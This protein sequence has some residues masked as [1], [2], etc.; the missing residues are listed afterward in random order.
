MRTPVLSSNM[1]RPNEIDSGSI[2]LKTD[3]S[4]DTDLPTQQLRASASSRVAVGS[5]M[6]RV[7]TDGPVHRVD[8]SA[9]GLPTVNLLSGLELVT[10][11]P[12]SEARL[13][14]AVGSSRFGFELLT[15]LG[16]GAFGRVYLARQSALADR[17][18]VLKVGTH[19]SDETQ[20]L[21]QLQHPNVA[22]VYSFHRDGR[23]QALCMPYLGPVTLA[24]VM[25]R[26]RTS[27]MSTLNGKALTTAIVE[28]RRVK[29][30]T[31]TAIGTT[32]LHHTGPTAPQSGPS[33]ASV[34]PQLATSPGRIKLDGLR[35]YNYVDAVLWVCQQLADGLTAAH[36]QK[37]VHSDLK[38]ANVLL[39][40][41]GQPMLLDFG[42]AYDQKCRSN[43]LKIGGT[44][45]YMAPEHIQSIRDEVMLFDG[46]SDIYSLGVILFELL[47][48]KLPFEPT[49]DSSLN[50]LN[51]EITNRQQVPSVRAINPV[52]PPA[53][54]S[55][56]QKCLVARTEER[57]QTAEQL[58]ED[59][60]RQLARRP[61]KYASNPSR[62]ELAVKWATRN[63]WLLI[64]GGVL[65]VSGGAIAGFAVRDAG[66]A[67]RIVSFESLQ[68]ADRFETE[69]RH[70]QAMLGL[71][72]TDAAGWEAAIQA[73]VKAL[74][75]HHVLETDRWW[76]TS[77]AAVLPGDRVDRLRLRVASLLL[78]LSRAAGVR[79]TMAHSGSER[80]AWF[81]K[82]ADWNQ[83]AERSFPADAIPRGVWTQRVWLANLSGDLLAADE[84]KRKAQQTPLISA[85]D[86]RIEGR[87]LMEQGKWREA[88]KLLAMA[89]ERD[90]TDF[91][92]AFGLGLSQY[93]LGHDAQAVAAYDVCAALDPSVPG[94]FFN[95]GLA[96]LRLKQ[97][98]KAADDFSRVIDVK[99]DWADPYLNR[100][101]AREALT[102]YRGSVR[103]LTR[104][105]DLGY[106]PT[107]VLL[108]RSR[109]YAK[110]GEDGLSKQDLA[111]GMKTPPTDERG[112]ITRGVARMPS[113]GKT[114]L[115][116]FENALS[117]F[118]E[119]LKI[120]PRSHAALQF[121]ARVYSICQENARAVEVLTELLKHY[122][123]SL[124][125]WSGRAMLYSRL[126]EREK[127]HADA[128]EA[129]RLGSENPK[130]VYQL[131]GVYAM[132]SQ[133]HPNDK[134]EAFR[135]LASALRNGFGL[136]LLD[137]D[138][139]LDPLRSDPEFSQVV[140]DAKR[141][142]ERRT[143]E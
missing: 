103:D 79:G 27:E 41:D 93:R 82:A 126:G 38:P 104:A 22:P 64:V 142:V 39:S 59:L 123:E 143:K 40:D 75:S 99:T 18:V 96:Y 10:A 36:A 21:A 129:L 58:K 130:T 72:A 55:I 23:L 14:P 88:T 54:E 53:V 140:E 125:A 8:T 102:D 137:Q 92:S 115:S 62:V 60:S 17:L 63:R 110:M 16:R 11:Q 111:E 4:I 76:E 34:N 89:M 73:G 7:T 43:D 31:V 61:L 116:D 80:S 107:A 12:D 32:Q 108:A 87:E 13:F 20:R 9:D 77:S 81:A 91:W 119:A 71:G 136:D 127:A 46:R 15:E 128:E 134:R 74:A 33:D 139:E 100:A 86:H 26:L 95:R 68:R 124:D 44:R 106:P 113:S 3:P 78:D 90:P 51:Q 85:V 118:G 122:P 131:A 47:T 30:P 57:Y 120:N 117:D 29:Q 45:P 114:K 135:L 83:R 35:G 84:A 98:Q 65:A 1:S 37:I 105:I 132:T 19:L 48:G 101:S 141:V 97:F 6:D 2:G 67:E 109:V 138:R 66:K 50:A 24:H 112:W 25:H 69:A 5:V 70:A 52:V 28:C 94:V 133:T 49:S 121:Q 42:V 56:V